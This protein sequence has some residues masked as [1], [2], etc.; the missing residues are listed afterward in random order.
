LNRTRLGALIGLVVL[1]GV[2]GSAS[3]AL[4]VAEV[5][6]FNLV[7]SGIPTHIEARDYN[8]RLDL[9]NRRYLESTGLEGIEK[10]KFGWLF[11]AELRLFV[12][13]N[14]AL[15]AGVGQLRRQTRR[16]YLPAILSDVQLRAELLSVP[17]HVGG[18]YYFQPYNQGDFQA[19]AYL[20]GGFMSVVYNRARLHAV[21]TGADTS[22]SVRNDFEVTGKG[23]SPG[24]YV[25]GGVHMFFAT[26]LSVLLGV[27][28]RSAMVRD[29]RGVL[30]IGN[31]TQKV[32][33]LSE[34]DPALPL[35]GLT[36][37][38]TSGIGVRMA[39][40]IGF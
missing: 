27:M 23:D 16:E 19:R 29:P 6:R 1:A 36:Q 34:T 38:D 24:Y 26:R 21:V 22:G 18:D 2:A 33:H 32:E 10:I 9:F 30:V 28:Y 40:G 14:V 25:E 31:Q 13:Q 39:L 3:R 15:T 20:G 12:R 8:N 5:H 37:V 7:I 4:A 35:G 11:D 17:V